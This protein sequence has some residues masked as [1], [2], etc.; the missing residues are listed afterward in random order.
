M[1]HS[2]ISHILFGSF[3]VFIMKIELTVLR[4]GCGDIQDEQSG[5]LT[6]WAKAYLVNDSFID[7]DMFTGVMDSSASIVD[8]TGNADVK[9]AD[10]IKMHLRNLESNN[11][12]KL[13]FEC[14]F[15]VSAKKQVLCIRGFN[16]A[17]QKSLPLMKKAVA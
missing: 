9:M 7:N 11:P 12:V 2:F 1:L 16:A 14:D 15:A 5:E 13:T 17:D 6:P 3:G 8:K 4:I 10:E